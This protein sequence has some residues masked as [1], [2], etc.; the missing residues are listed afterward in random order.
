MKDVT[1]LLLNMC[2]KNMPYQPFTA[3]RSKFNGNS[4]HK[5]L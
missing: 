1:V 4:F 2:M 5:Q 3:I